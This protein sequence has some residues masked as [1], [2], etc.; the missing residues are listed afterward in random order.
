MKA[1]LY[2]M[3]I[4]A[5]LFSCS[6]G[7]NKTNITTYVRDSVANS[8]PE[9]GT[10]LILALHKKVLLSTTKEHLF[11][12]SLKK[13]T[14]KLVLKGDSLHKS[15]ALFSIISFKGERIYADTFAGTAFAA[16]T[17][18][19]TVFPVA[20]VEK[21]IK[22]GVK[23]F[24]TDSLFTTPRI[25]ADEKSISGSDSTNWEDIKT[26]KTAIGFQYTND[27]VEVRIAYSKKQQKVLDYWSIE[28]G[29]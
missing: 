23:S 20:Q 29:D 1:L 8:I 22:E 24:F 17:D 13:D 4:S 11:S 28:M 10:Y 27:E 14:F 2:S 5:L 15:V 21:T 3:V 19:D 26:D 6:G 16:Y 7:N 12:D 9:M 25:A 18:E